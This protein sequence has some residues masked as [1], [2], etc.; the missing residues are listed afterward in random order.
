MSVASVTPLYGSS[1]GY[2]RLINL[3]LSS[4]SNYGKNSVHIAAPG[5]YSEG[6][7]GGRG[8]LSAYSA[9]GDWGN[10]YVKKQGTS[11]ASPVV[12]GVAG[13]MR[14]VNPSLT[15]YEI[16]DLMLRAAKSHSSL[17]KIQNSALL[18]AHSAITLAKNTKSKGTKPRIP[19]KAV[20]NSTPSGPKFEDTSGCAS[21]TLASGGGGTSNPFGGNSL[22]LLGA[23]YIL[24]SSGRSVQKR[25]QA[26]KKM[27]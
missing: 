16:K 6:R 9:Y 1:G 4:F 7:G 18:H 8:I 23:L 24:W 13:V 15:S 20:A 27:C 25:R 3:A 19:S 11:M 2:F 14:A 12:A 21:G 17:D 22:G 10:L 5:D 26:N